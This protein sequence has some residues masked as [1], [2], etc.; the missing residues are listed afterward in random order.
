MRAIRLARLDKARPVL[1][2]TRQ[3]V[4]DVLDW[5]SV[6]PITSTVR[7]VS[8]EVPVGLDNGLDHA[9]VVSCDNIQ[10][11]PKASLG[12]ALGFLHEHQEAELAAAVANAFDLRVEEML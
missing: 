1:V 11:V 10:T 9:S 12:R 7:G 4:L 6:A 5:V 8:T 3:P 2:L